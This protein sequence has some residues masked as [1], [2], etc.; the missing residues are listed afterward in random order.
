M[1]NAIHMSAFFTPP[2]QIFLTSRPVEIH[3]W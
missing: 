1:F 3:T 2:L